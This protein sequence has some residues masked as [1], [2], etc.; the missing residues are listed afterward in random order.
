MIVEGALDALAIAGA[1]RAAGLAD[2]FQP[3]CTSG[4]SFSEIR[5]S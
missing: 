5:S 4:L 3:V 2:R 1:A